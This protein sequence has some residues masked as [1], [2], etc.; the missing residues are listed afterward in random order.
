[1]TIGTSSSPRRST[2]RRA[3]ARNEKLRS[4]TTVAWRT[5]S[6]ADVDIASPDRD[7]DAPQPE[8]RVGGADAGRQVVLPAVPRADD[9]RLVVDEALA[10]DGAVWPQHGLVPA[11][12]LAGADRPALVAA[13]ILVRAQ[14]AADPEDADLDAAG[15]REHA[16]PLGDLLGRSDPVIGGHR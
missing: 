3:L 15:D 8:A 9:A 13:A 16:A 2:S 6:D 4:G 14:L 12:D 11:Q 1:S 7:L 5:S 10:G